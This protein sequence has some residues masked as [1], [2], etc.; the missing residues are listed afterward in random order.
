MLKALAVLIAGLV[1]AHIVQAQERIKLS[2]VELQE[3]LNEYSA[4]AGSNA[5]SGCVFMVVNH[6]PAK[7]EMYYDCYSRP[8]TYKGSARV[9]GDMLCIKWEP[10]EERCAEVYRIGG[11]QY[12]TTGMEGNVVR[13][14]RLK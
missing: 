9:E 12:E 11:N 1:S 6:A 2:G 5:A 8:G 14:Y 13:Y 3:Q 7:R 4:Y 10:R